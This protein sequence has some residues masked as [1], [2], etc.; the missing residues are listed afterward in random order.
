MK[1]VKFTQMKDGTKEDYLLLEKHEKKFIEETP[2]RILK[3]MSSLTSTL[4]GYQVS[5]LEHSLQAASRALRDRAD[6][7]MIVA[8]LLHD[9]G[10]EIA[11][12]NHSEISAAV[13]RP[14]VSEKTHWIVQQHGLFQAYYYN[15][16]YGHDR[17]LRDKYKG[18][19]FYNDTIRFCETYDQNSFDPAYDTIKLEEFIPMV[20]RIF[21]RE[22]HKHVY[23]GL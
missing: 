22:P 10:D 6:E 7:E 11:P 12:L 4:E 18:H 5:R 16:H 23:L 3:Y 2:S 19:P 14:F 1:K 15:H 21:D 17:N 20:H 8:S 9:I 13:L